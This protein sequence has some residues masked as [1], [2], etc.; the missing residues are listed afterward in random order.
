GLCPIT[1][2][3]LGDGIFDGVRWLDAGGAMAI[4]SD[5]NIRIALS[6][7]MRTLEYTQRLRDH[8]RA[9]LATPGQSTGRRV[10]DSMLN[11]GA[12]AAGRKTGKL[13]RGY[14]ADLLVLDTSAPHLDGRTG[15]TLLDTW[16]FAADDRLVTDVWSAGRHVV[17]NGRHIRH[18]II[19]DTYRRTLS[20]L[21]DAL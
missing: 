17:Q 15:D 21:R 2:S 7:E 12:Q 1:E 19:S 18:Q 3:S 11:G 9:T 20:E 8:S 16:I 10:F 6:E 4:G 5:S 14:L 13:D